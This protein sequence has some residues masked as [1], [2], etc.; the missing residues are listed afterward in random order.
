[1]QISIYACFKLFQIHKIFV[2]TR[3]RSQSCQLLEKMSSTKNMF[4]FYLYLKALN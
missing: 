1:M 3:Q 4:L 2:I